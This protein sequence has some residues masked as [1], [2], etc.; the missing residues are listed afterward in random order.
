[1]SA[2]TSYDI[3][4]IKI[5]RKDAAAVSASPDVLRRFAHC[6]GVTFMGSIQCSRRLISE[7]VSCRWSPLENPDSGDYA[8]SVPMS[9]SAARQGFFSHHE[10]TISVVKDGAQ[11]KFDLVRSAVLLFISV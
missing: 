10:E 9:I 1:V 4:I 6:G 8:L 11:W 5:R 7:F 3:E 2:D